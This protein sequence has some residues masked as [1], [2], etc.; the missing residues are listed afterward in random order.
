[1]IPM[2]VRLIWSAER[3]NVE[4]TVVAIWQSRLDMQAVPLAGSTF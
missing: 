4:P 2:S 1:M 3:Y